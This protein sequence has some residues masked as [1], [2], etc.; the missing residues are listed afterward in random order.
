MEIIIVAIICNLIMALLILSGVLSAMRNGIKL[1]LIKLFMMLTGGVGAYF[2]APLISNSI[3]KIEGMEALLSN[4]NVGISY[5]TINSCLFLL[6]FLLFYAIALMACSIIKHFMI[7]NLRDK[8]SDSLKIKRA[9]S[10]NPKAERAVARAKWKV[11][12]SKYLEKLMWYNRLISGIL[13]AIISIVV[14]YITIMPYGY[15]AKDISNKEKDKIYLSNGY[16]YTLNGLVGDS[17]SDFL[18]NSKNEPIKS[19]KT[20]DKV[21]K[22]DFPSGE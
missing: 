13:G 2:L 20:D 5:S 10:I 11:L 17:A 21:E 22:E 12:K 6:W 3:Y 8:G 4:P 1:T 18:A 9:K 15:I 14:G 16:E 19:E 7:K